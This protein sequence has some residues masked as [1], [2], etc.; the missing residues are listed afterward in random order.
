[1]TGGN[2]LSVREGPVIYKQ[3]PLIN[4]PRHH[5][6]PPQHA[7]VAKPPSKTTIGGKLTGFAKF[8][9]FNT[10]FYTLRG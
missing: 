8:N 10:W 1:M 9:V 6:S 7:S 5:Q 4:R 2:H 3:G